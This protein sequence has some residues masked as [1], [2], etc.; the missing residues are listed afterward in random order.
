MNQTT[1][2]HR[3]ERW[4]GEINNK[5]TDE[6]ENQESQGKDKKTEVRIKERSRVGRKRDQQWD[7]EIKS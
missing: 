4:W 1:A 3:N 7:R 2:E 6:K 5:K